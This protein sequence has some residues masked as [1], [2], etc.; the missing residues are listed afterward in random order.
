MQET[1]LQQGIDLMVY[2]MGT[3]LVFLT[4]LVIAT[5]CMSRLMLRY[6]PDPV[7]IEPKK[8]ARAASGGA[9]VVEPR[10]ER[11]IAEAVRQHRARR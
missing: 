11:V 3:V 4:L 7:V 6:F 9:A 5:M 1:L 8:K 10:I 2:G